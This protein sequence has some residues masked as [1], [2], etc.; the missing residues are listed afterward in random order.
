MYPILR[1][2]GDLSFQLIIFKFQLFLL[3]ETRE[4]K[5]DHYARVIQKAF[6]QYFNKQKFLRQKEEAAGIFLSYTRNAILKGC[7]IM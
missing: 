5:I 4:R 1:Q 3:E 6:Q 7:R 2:D